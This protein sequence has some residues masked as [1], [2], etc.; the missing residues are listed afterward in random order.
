M[1]G[2]KPTHTYHFGERAP[3]LRAMYPNGIPVEAT[4]HGAD[5]ET[6]WVCDAAGNGAGYAAKD[7]KPN[8]N[9]S[10][11]KPLK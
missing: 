10:Y 2:F 4:K 7:G 8:G 6:F 11:V 3:K 9:G 1:S 5:G